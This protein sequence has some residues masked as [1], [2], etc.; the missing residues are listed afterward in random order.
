MTAAYADTLSI[1]IGHGIN[2]ETSFHQIYLILSL[3]AKHPVAELA[4]ANFS[5]VQIRNSALSE[6][7]VAA[8]AS[9][10]T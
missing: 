8:V 9:M 3:Q 7:Q 10:F 4:S 2:M 1:P 5:Y 6:N